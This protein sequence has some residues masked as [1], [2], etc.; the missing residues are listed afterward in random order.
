MGWSHSREDEM[1]G[2]TVGRMGWMVPHEGGED[3][4]VPYRVGRM[5]CMIP[6]SG[7]DGMFPHSSC[8]PCFPPLSYKEEKCLMIGLIETGK[9]KAMA[10]MLISPIMAGL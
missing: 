2:F 3:G 8:S 10:T 7:E 4:M 5:G 1:E 6:H 9:S